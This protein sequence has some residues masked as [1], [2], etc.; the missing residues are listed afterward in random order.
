MSNQLLPKFWEEEVIL[1]EKIKHGKFLNK[2]KLA[3]QPHLRY[4]KMKF[5][6]YHFLEGN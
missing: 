4:V 6:N 5:L 1:V 2:A 3:F